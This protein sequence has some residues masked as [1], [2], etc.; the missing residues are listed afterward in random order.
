M[1]Q[2][3]W[4]A[5]LPYVFRQESEGFTFR[6]CPIRKSPDQS[7]LTTPR[8]L[9]Q[10]AT[11]FIA[12]F[13]QGIHQT[14]LS[15][16]ATDQIVKEQIFGDFANKYYTP[17]SFFLSNTFVYPYLPVICSYLLPPCRTRTI[18]YTQ[19]TPD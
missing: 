4:F 16:L 10:L 2:F 14:P 15:C 17:Y 19:L 9:S 3:S 11:S 5:F 18:T 6:G 7:L 8:G 1:V 12:G 13:R